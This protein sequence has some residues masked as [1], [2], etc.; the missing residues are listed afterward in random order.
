[1][2]KKTD[3]KAAV[4]LSDAEKLDVLS[5][6]ESSYLLVYL[7]VRA[8]GRALL[9]GGVRG[10]FAGGPRSSTSS[11]ASYWNSKVSKVFLL[12]AV[13]ASG[14]GLIA[15]GCWTWMHIPTCPQPAI[16]V[17]GVP[18]QSVSFG[19]ARLRSIPEGVMAARRLSQVDKVKTASVNNG[20]PQEKSL[21]ELKNWR[22]ILGILIIAVSCIAA[23]SAGTGGGSI[24]VPIMTLVMG[25][26][27]HAATVMSQSLMCGG[28][29]AGT[30]LNLCQR[31]P[32]ADRPLVDLDLV[33]LL[34]PAQMAAV[35]FGMVLNRCLPAWLLVVALVAVLSV[36]VAQTIKQYKKIKE[37]RLSR[38][39]AALSAPDIELEEAVEFAEGAPALSMETSIALR[40]ASTMQPPLEPTA[41]VVFP[42]PCMEPT[43]QPGL[44]V[45]EVKEYGPPQRGSVSSTESAVL[46]SIG[47]DASSRDWTCR[48][49][50]VQ[51]A[52]LKVEPS[53][54][55]GPV[56]VNVTRAGFE[57]RTPAEVPETPQE[58]A[59]P[60]EKAIV[61]CLP[62]RRSKFHMARL[63]KARRK[64]KEMQHR[65][66]ILKWFLMAAIWLVDMSLGIIRGGKGSSI[67]LVPYCGWAHWLIYFLA[68]LMLLGC[69]YF[70]GIALY[71]L[72]R[73]KD[74]A[75][76]PRAPGDLHFDL[77]T[78]H[79]LFGQT[80]VAG[81][82]AGTVGIG[83]SLV[84]G[85]LMLMKG[86][87]PVVCTAVNTAL[88]LFSS[89]SAALKS[90]LGSAAPLE[91]CAF[92]FGLCFVC[93]FIGKWIVDGMV[94]K[95]NADHI[96]VLFMIIIMFGSMGCMAAAGIIGLVNNEGQSFKG[97]CA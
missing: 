21:A 57:L 81:L 25:F 34:A 52:E 93:A 43:A 97:P 78:V 23:V 53:I 92:L 36:A 73:G 18:L 76:I 56:K 6:I 29:L 58:D 68:A 94:R 85:P 41:E 14:A 32:F 71:R 3:Q 39:T 51:A 48:A 19:D 26:P 79:L 91:Y 44:G 86:M 24:Y 88:V 66:D 46:A 61:A 37:K 83:S 64:L 5:I 35:S 95:Y 31:H 54:L 27:P 84:M 17:V 55:E 45:E 30:L 28:V 72:Q 80:V 96:V 22:D 67:H 89:S 90:L 38:F 15:G 2:G 10:P 50:S 47:D 42:K 16:N 20:V 40:E 87:L 60:E 69:S 65:H 49:D 70:Q 4:L 77:A 74:E 59:I 1:M 9:M 11:A 12:T 8:A 62:P 75:A 7:L 13:L 33:I 82:V 63:R